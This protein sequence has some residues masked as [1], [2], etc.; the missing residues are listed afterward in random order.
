[1]DS[2]VEVVIAFLFNRSGKEG[3]SFSDLY[4]TLSMDLNW[5]TPEEAKKFVNESLK[6]K[7]LTKK[8]NLIKPGF[9]I[10]KITVP[11]GFHPSKRLFQKP[12]VAEEKKDIF[13]EIVK[14]IA[15][16]TK[17]D[18]KDIISKI[19]EVEIE[20]NLT[21]EVAALLIGKENGVSLDDLFEKIEEKIF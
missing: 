7:L 14:R 12:Q 8:G 1:M 13:D 10:D 20:K 19:K 15:E 2:E 18:E 11:V 21:S 3:L 17:L 4:L 5:F 9:D 16:K 6:K